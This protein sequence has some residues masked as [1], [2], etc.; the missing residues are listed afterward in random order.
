[1]DGADKEYDLHR[2][3]DLRRSSIKNIGTIVSI[4]GLK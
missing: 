4:V 3:N 1:M 2:N